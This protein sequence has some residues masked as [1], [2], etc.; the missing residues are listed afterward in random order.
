MV[1]TR[2]E[3]ADVE[4]LVA[5]SKQTFIDAFEK[6]TDP[7]NFNIYISTA[8]T[9]SV[10]EAELAHEASVFYFLK[11]DALQTVGYMKLRWDR[12]TEVM[13]QE[14]ALELQRIYFLEKYWNKGYGKILLDFAEN[15]ATN[16]QFT[17]IYLCVWYKNDGAIRFYERHGWAIFSRKNFQF[18]N[19]IHHDFLLRKKTG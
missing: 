4:A 6:T 11:D 9:P 16:N 15:F 1:I 3:K 2:C 19:E 7:D 14:K 5:L 13:G 18:G 8:F 17:W 12:S 10:I